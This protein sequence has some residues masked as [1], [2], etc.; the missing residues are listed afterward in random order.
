MKINIILLCIFLQLITANLISAEAGIIKEAPEGLMEAA[1]EILRKYFSNLMKRKEY[2]P[3]YF[4]PDENILNFKLGE[5]LPLYRVLVKDIYLLQ[6]PEDLH[7]KLTFSEWMFPI[8]IADEKQPRTL[9]GV[10]KGDEGE[11]RF[12]AWCY[13]GMGGRAKHLTEARERYP[14]DE[15][16]RHALIRTYR[17]FYSYKLILIEK[18]HDLF[19][20]ISSEDSDIADIF[21]VSKN[22]DGY[23][24]LL[25]R[26]R[27]VRE[28]KNRDLNKR[29][30]EK[31]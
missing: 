18:D 19:V 4:H 24:P 17:G 28:I 9:M 21:G 5:P 15:G 16:Y 14:A 3:S 2:L 10:T 20:F 25:S 13:A 26:D 31:K 8:Y 7:Q 30:F 6:T 12:G 11:L 29:R 22:K 27:F 23:Y 1:E